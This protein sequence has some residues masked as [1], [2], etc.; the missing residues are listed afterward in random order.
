MDVEKPQADGDLRLVTKRH[1]LGSAIPRRSGGLGDYSSKAPT[2][3]CL[4]ALPH[5]APQAI[6][7]FLLLRDQSSCCF[8]SENAMNNFGNGQWITFQQKIEFLPCHIT[9]ATTAIEPLFPLA[10]HQI[11]ENSQSPVVSGDSVVGI[12]SSHFGT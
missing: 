9:S 3:P 4:Q 6:G 8:L 1:I 7:L 5:T 2:D 12:M 11:D 10:T